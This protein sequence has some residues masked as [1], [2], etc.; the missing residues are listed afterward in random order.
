MTNAAAETELSKSKDLF[1]LTDNMLRLSTTTA[2]TVE[3][4]HIV[5][6]PYINNT[7]IITI[8]AS[9][10]AKA[11]TKPGIMARIVQSSGSAPRSTG[12]MMFVTED[13]IVGTVGGGS[14]ESHT[15]LLAREMLR[16]GEDCR[17]EHHTLTADQ[18]LGMVCGGDSTI[19]LK[20]I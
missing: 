14:I 13:D 18:P 9:V 1:R 20:R 12:S 2:L 15:I 7:S 3:E 5:I 6:S 8:D 11:A 19:L 16:S 17:I 10:L 4:L